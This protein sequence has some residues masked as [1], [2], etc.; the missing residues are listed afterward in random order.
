MLAKVKKAIILPARDR[1]LSDL[2]SQPT[3]IS[4][5]HV[6]VSDLSHPGISAGCL[7]A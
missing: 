2:F 5:E 1:V 3:E 4:A 7:N 6:C